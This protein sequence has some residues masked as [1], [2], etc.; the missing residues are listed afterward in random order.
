MQISY[1]KKTHDI[2]YIPNKYKTI[3]ETY[4]GST[5]WFYELTSLYVCIL[6]RL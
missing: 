1:K 4:F 5:F 3:V 6:F 2:V